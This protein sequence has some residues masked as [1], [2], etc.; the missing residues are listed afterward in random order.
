M[1][2]QASEAT[3]RC[4]KVR[5]TSEARSGLSNR[6]G[7][8]NPVRSDVYTPLDRGYREEGTVGQAMPRSALSM[9]N[10]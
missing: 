1:A 10:G 6:S 9:I 2:G 4:P 8:R 3:V 5:V 7:G